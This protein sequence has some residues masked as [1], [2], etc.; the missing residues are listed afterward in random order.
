M[1]TIWTVLMVLVSVAA[2]TVSARAAVVSVR[3]FNSEF[4]PDPTINLNDTVRWEWDPNIF[5]HS[6]TSAT[7]LLESWDS[8]LKD[9]PFT[10]DHTFTNV[11]SFAYYC[12]AH[13]VDNLDGTTSGMAGVVTVVPEPVSIGLFSLGAI[14][15]IGRRRR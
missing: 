9:D 4:D 6:T 11:G 10:F 3:V 12:R 2:L 7:G 15:L 13:G 5:L 14:V 1:K 8:G